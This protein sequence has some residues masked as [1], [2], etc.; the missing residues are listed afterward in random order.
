MAG[1]AKTSGVKKPKKHSKKN[2][3]PSQ[4][5][6]VKNGRHQEKET[7]KNVRR[8]VAAIPPTL[9]GKVEVSDDEHDFATDTPL[10][11]VE[12]LD[13]DSEPGPNEFS[14][15]FDPETTEPTLDEMNN[16]DNND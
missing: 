12:E 4:K 13:F 2:V 3:C 11:Y 9:E 7:K 5:K 16:S 15:I 6:S 14:D 8:A 10:E 1:V